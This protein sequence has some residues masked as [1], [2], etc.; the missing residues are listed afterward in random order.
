M[1]DHLDVVHKL[2]VEVSYLVGVLPFFR[3]VLFDTVV[4]AVHGL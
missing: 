1:P 2:S 3:H 4:C